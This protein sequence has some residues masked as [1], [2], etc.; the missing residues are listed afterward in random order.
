[1]L[2]EGISHSA[3]SKELGRSTKTVQRVKKS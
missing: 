3:I 2:A 1:M